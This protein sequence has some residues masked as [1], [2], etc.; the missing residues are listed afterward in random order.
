LACRR[1]EGGRH[2]ERKFGTEVFSECECRLLSGAAAQKLQSGQT[3][4]VGVYFQFREPLRFVV[5]VVVPCSGVV[6]CRGFVLKRSCWFLPARYLFSLVCLVEFIVLKRVFC[7]LVGGF[8]ER[9]VNYTSTWISHAVVSIVSTWQ[10][11]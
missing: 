2:I 8:F 10:L 5:R 3:L 11:V 4:S 7:E 6:S 1:R 9:A